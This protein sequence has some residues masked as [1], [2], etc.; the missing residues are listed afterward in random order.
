MTLMIYKPPTYYEVQM[1]VT[2]GYY[3]TPA[4][5]E[6]MGIMAAGLSGTV[7]LDV[8][9]WVKPVYRINKRGGNNGTLKPIDGEPTRPLNNEDDGA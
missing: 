3:D 7:E 4:E 2:L 5:A 9:K 6:A 1:V 8:T